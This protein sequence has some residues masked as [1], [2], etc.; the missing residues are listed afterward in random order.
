MVEAIARINGKPRCVPLNPERDGY[1]WIRRWRGGP[2][3]PFHWNATWYRN[4]DNG[5][6]A[7]SQPDR[8]D[9]WEYLGPCPSP[10]DAQEQNDVRRI[11][12]EQARDEGL[13]FQA[14]TCAEAYVQTALRKLHAAAEGDKSVIFPAVAIMPNKRA[15][16]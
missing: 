11:V 9:Q 14:Q 2:A 15:G 7:W 13:W 6:G 3:V 4:A 1:H 10:D 16:G 8:E 12:D 5:W